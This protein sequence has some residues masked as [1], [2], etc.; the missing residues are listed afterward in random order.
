MIRKF[1]YEYIALPQRTKVLAYDV[2]TDES[3]EIILIDSVHVC[4]HYPEGIE[5]A[6]SEKEYKHNLEKDYER[7]YNHG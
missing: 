6:E 7:Y 5:I 2:D 4:I 3:K 1:N